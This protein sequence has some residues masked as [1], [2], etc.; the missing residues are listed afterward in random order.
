MEQGLSGVYDATVKLSCES[1]TAV[2]PLNSP[3]KGSS[4]DVVTIAVISTVP[5]GTN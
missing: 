2:T 1:M 5:S 3:F 4:R